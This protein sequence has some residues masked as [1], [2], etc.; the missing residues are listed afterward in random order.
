MKKYFQN[1]IDELSSHVKIVSPE[2]ADLLHKIP[3][4]VSLGMEE[5]K[6]LIILNEIIALDE[7]KFGLSRKG[8]GISSEVIGAV[9]WSIYSFLCHPYN[10][11]DCIATAYWP[12]GDV[13]TTGAMAGAISGAV[14]G[15]RNLKPIDLVSI[16]KDKKNT[17]WTTARL[18]ALVEKCYE[19]Y[20]NAC[21]TK[22][23][24]SYGNS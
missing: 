24:E 22:Y 2:F 4:W 16:L 1:F 14:V 10:F 23:K 5:E 15:F 9:L 20:N 3:N 6:M 7:R 13:D 12:G 18:K 19:Y 17:E 8:L 11:I 21:I